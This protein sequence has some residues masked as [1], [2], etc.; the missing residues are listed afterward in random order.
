MRPDLKTSSGILNL[1]NTTT[2]KLLKNEL[3][4]EVAR[5]VFYACSVAG[6]IIKTLEL[7][8]RLELLEDAEQKKGA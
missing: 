5:T 2:Q 8:Q 6:Q 7:E 1:L 3:K 4:V